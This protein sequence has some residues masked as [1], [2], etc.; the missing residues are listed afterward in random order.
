MLIIQFIHKKNSDRWILYDTDI[1]AYVRFL[2]SEVLFSSFWPVIEYLILIHIQ[3]PII[4]ISHNHSDFGAQIQC[5]GSDGLFSSL[6]VCIFFHYIKFLIDGYITQPY[7]FWALK[8]MYVPRRLIFA[9]L[10]PKS[11]FF[12]IKLPIDRLITQQYRF[13]STYSVFGLWGL[14]L[15]F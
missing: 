9:F 3:F 11:I 12:R 1:G 8:S 5:L 2:V 13:W 15:T 10:T 6:T 7:W 14:I 4:D